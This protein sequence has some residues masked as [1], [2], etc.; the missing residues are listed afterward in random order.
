[1]KRYMN[2]YYIQSSRS[3]VKHLSYRGKVCLTELLDF[4]EEVK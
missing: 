1:M 3:V 4:C 2:K